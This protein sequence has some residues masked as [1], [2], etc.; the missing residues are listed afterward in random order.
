M[1]QQ[2]VLEKISITPLF[3]FYVLSIATRVSRELNSVA[4]D[5]A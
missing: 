3:S 2:S 4:R 1:Q 5:N